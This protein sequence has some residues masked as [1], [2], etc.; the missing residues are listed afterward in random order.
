MSAREDLVAFEKEIDASVATLSVLKVPLNAV[1]TT[2]FMTIDSLFHGS[3]FGEQTRPRS[4]AG[5]AAASRMSYILPHLLACPAEFVGA[6]AANSMLALDEDQYP[7]INLLLQYGHFC[8]IMPEVH[9]GL[10]S[11]S[12]G[13]TEFALEHASQSVANGEARD[14][15]L[16]EV[17]MPFFLPPSI[18]QAYFDALVNMLPSSDLGHL[19]ESVAR[20]YAHYKNHSYE[21]PLLSSD[22]FLKATGASYEDFVR[23]RA[24]WVAVAEFSLGMADAIARRLRAGVSDAGK[25]MLE[26]ELCEW[27]SPRLKSTFLSGLIIAVAE[28]DGSKFDALMRVFSVDTQTKSHQHAGDG[29]LPPVFSSSKSYLFNPDVLRIMLSGRNVPY[30]I[31]RT[32]RR[33]FDTLVSQDLEPQLL[34]AAEAIIRRIQGIKIARNF[35]WFD[36]EIDMLAYHTTDN[37]ALHF[38]AKAALPP[39]GA[40]MV[41]RVEGRSREGL[42]QLATFRALPQKQI[43][44][45]ISSSLKHPV[46][47]VKIVD[48]LLCRSSVGSYRIWEHLKNVSAVNLPVLNATVDRLRSLDRRL[49]EFGNTSNELLDELSA[50]AIKGWRRESIDLNGTKLTFPILDLD[51]EAVD[52][53]RMRWHPR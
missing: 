12:G 52:R 33:M 23:F 8:E 36:G 19:V 22:T 39:Q 9:R 13:E 35:R 43:D 50:A 45:I 6:N 29:Y 46:K 25:S 26:T 32:D 17:A 53:F 37:V 16:T 34:N 40:R 2:M 51:N 3:R 30:V 31:N 48:V 1:L 49:S 18:N 27:I 28:L 5:Y 7:E 11:V 47:D 15:L 42:E 20:V 21:S 44:E 4:V 10:Y 24:A 14:I 38:Q 41:D